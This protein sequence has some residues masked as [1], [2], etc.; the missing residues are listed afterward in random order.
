MLKFEIVV[1]HLQIAS[2]WRNDEEFGRQILNGAHPCRIERVRELPL[3][4]R[5]K[6]DLIESFLDRK[7]SLDEEIKV[8]QMI[9]MMMRLFVKINVLHRMVTYTC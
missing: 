4:F 3:E 7:K 1:S 8:V 5:A 6:R 9:L 2:K